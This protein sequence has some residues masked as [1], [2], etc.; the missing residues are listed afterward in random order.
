MNPIY[1]LY[2]TRS[3][4][5]GTHGH[6][7][8]AVGDLLCYTIERPW[9]GNAHDVS[10]I[11]DS[12]DGYPF[13]PHTKSNNGQQCWIASGVPN[14]TGIL[15]HTGNTEGDSEGCIIIGLMFS[16]QGVEESELA[17]QKLQSTLPSNF[18]LRIISTM[19]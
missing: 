7:E 11:P 16:I 6:I 8:D 1:T 5:Y 15:I 18:T 4:Q 19:F 9:L 12:N 13:S 2:R 3:D 10:C 14:R 17:L